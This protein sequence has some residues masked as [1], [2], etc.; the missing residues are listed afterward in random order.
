MFQTR[1]DCTTQKIH[2]NAMYLITQSSLNT[3]LV[4]ANINLFGGSQE[5][6]R[7]HGKYWIYDFTTNSGT[8]F[9]VLF[10]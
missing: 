4:L 7:P 2:Y 10:P 5:Y 1:P 3:E 9:L 6:W 8:K